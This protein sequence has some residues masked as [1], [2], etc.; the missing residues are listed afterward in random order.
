MYFWKCKV[1]L[2]RF[3]KGEDLD[4][5]SDR[6]CGATNIVK[7]IQRQKYFWKCKLDLF[8]FERGGGAWVLGYD[9]DRFCGVHTQ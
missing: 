9:F 3:D 8:W 6:F 5:R 2:F 4:L 1:D 7:V